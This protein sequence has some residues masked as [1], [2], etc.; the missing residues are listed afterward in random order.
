MQTDKEFEDFFREQLNGLEETPPPNAWN[1][2]NKDLKPPRT[3]HREL[4]ALAL[5]L[6]ISIGTYF[7]YEKLAGKKGQ[8][9]GTAAQVASSNV[10][11]TKEN[12]T[13]T[14]PTEITTAQPV[15]ENAIE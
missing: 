3:W 6:L 13:E 8:E 12:K 14:K 1:K 10:Q 11:G 7:G 9:N 4:A 15:A 5:V 2:I